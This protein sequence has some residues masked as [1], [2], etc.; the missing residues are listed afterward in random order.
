[1]QSRGYQ[2]FLFFTHFNYVASA[3]VLI[4]LKLSVVITPIDRNPQF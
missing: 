4:L 3:S 2:K 1:M